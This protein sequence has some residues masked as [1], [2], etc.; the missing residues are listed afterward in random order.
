MFRADV[1]NNSYCLEQTSKV[2]V[3][4]IIVVFNIL[5]KKKNDMLLKYMLICNDDNADLQ[6]SSFWYVFMLS[7]SV[8]C[9]K[10]HVEFKQKIFVYS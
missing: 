5:K 1:N 6:N 7:S 4:F 2:C 3:A 10:T 8:Q 9:S